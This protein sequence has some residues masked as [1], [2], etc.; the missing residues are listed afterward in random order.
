MSHSTNVLNVLFMTL[1]HYPE[2]VE[3]LLG[4]NIE[5]RQ[6]NLEQ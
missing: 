4:D 6:V 2:E 3:L 5:T 1:Q